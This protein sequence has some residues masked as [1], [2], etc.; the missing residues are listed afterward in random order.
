[1]QGATRTASEGVAAVTALRRGVGLF[2]THVAFERSAAFEAEAAAEAEADKAAAEE[3][4]KAKAAGGGG[5]G[6]K[7][8]AKDEAAPTEE[9]LEALAIADAKAKAQKRMKQ[10]HGWL[11]SVAQNARIVGY[12][13]HWGFVNCA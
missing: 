4:A 2:D 9:E 6:K 10:V 13:F 3:A 5:G 11:V 1:V 12:V 7:K 8:A